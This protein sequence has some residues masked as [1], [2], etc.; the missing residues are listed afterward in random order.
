MTVDRLPESLREGSNGGREHAGL[1]TPTILSMCDRV[2]C[3]V[4]RR[5]HMFGWLRAPG[6]SAGAE[7]PPSGAADHRQWLA[8][9][10]YYPRSRLVVMCRPSP[11]RHEALYRE[12]I[13]AHGL[14]LLTLDPVAL[15]D[16][17]Q[18]VEAALA[19]RILD[20]KHVPRRSVRNLS[21]APVSSQAPVSSHA[22]TSR[23]TDPEATKWT[24]VSVER[25]P[26]SPAVEHGLGVLAGLALTVLLVAELCLA[27]VVV[28]LQAGR[29]VLGLAIALEACSRGLGTVAA[30]RAGER[31]WASACAIGG[32]PAVAWF[33]LAPREGRGHAE[34]APLAGL[35]AVLAGVVALV[36]L[37]IGS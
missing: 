14:G 12:L 30:E 1:S 3:E 31:G 2:L 4:G 6:P 5:S 20:L 24:R 35:L 19:R 25:T 32:S 13:P 33:A 11:G 16:D 7:A 21:T 27:V 15:G 37:L 26:V 22:P 18:A 17:P 28:G 34:P 10:A 29:P 8:V 23:A 9:D 36:A